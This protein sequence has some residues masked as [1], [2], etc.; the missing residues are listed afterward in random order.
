M[1]DNKLT[2][3]FCKLL[4]LFAKVH[5]LGGGANF[6]LSVT[7]TD[8]IHPAP[9]SAETTVQH[10]TERVGGAT[11]YKYLSRNVK[12]RTLPSAFSVDVQKGK[13]VHLL[14]SPKT[15]NTSSST[16]LSWNKQEVGQFEIK[17]IFMILTGRFK[18]L[19]LNEVLLKYRP[20]TWSVCH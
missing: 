7:S 5:G 16:A 14:G 8:F 4:W 15:T 13:S 10:W 11:E 9:K 20:Q 1:L 3:P 19:H 2:L 17:M 18:S 6:Y 12:L